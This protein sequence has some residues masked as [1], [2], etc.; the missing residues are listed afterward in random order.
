MLKPGNV[1][2]YLKAVSQVVNNN[3][4]PTSQVAVL[5]KKDVTKTP[6][7]LL[8]SYSLSKSLPSGNVSVKSGPG[9]TTTTQVRYAHTDINV[10]DW[11]EYRRDSTKSPTSKD[12][13]GSRKGFT[14]L[15]A[16]AGCLGSTYAA[17]T[18][19]THFVASMS[20]SADVLALA[21]IEIKLS[22]IPEGKS[23]TFKWRG[24]ILTLVKLCIIFDNIF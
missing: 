6:V 18:I 21:K 9:V 2:N 24:K 1:T 17:K 8:T 3:L 12:T 16:G 7:L 5:T 23:V 10:P 20:A 14:Y 13:D 15:M 4:K 11:S 19:V 22:E